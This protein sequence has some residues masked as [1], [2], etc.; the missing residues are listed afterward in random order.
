VCIKQDVAESWGVLDVLVEAL[1]A[2]FDV[3]WKAAIVQKST[4]SVCS[5]GKRDGEWPEFER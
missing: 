1:E 3:K 2:A 5:D 4:P